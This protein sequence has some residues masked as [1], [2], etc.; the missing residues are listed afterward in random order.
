MVKALHFLIVIFGLALFEIITSIDN[1]VV[2]A[3]V[4]KTLLE[5]YRYVRCFNDFKKFWSRI[6]FLIEKSNIMK[7]FKIIRLKNKNQF[8]LDNTLIGTTCSFFNFSLNFFKS[9]NPF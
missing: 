7:R 6:S 3:H 2:N 1:A 5:K 4:L 9:N 8:S